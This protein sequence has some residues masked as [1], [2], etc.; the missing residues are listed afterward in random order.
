MNL[1]S[2]TRLLTLIG[3]MTLMLAMGLKSPPAS[4]LNSL[5]QPRLVLMTLVANYILVPAVTVALLMLFQPTPLVAAGFLI[6]AAC[7][8]APVA[9]PLVALAKGDTS[10]ST[11]QLILLAGTSAVLSPLLLWLLFKRLLPH[12]ELPID[13][14]ALLR[15]LFLLQLLPLGVGLGIHHC[16]PAFSAAVAKPLSSIANLLLLAV[17]TLLL[18]TQYDMLSEIRLRGWSGMMLLLGLSLGIGWLCGGPGVPGRMS[19]SLTTAVRNAA[20]ALVIVAGPLTGTP[21]ATAVVAFSLVSILGALLT[22]PLL[23][24]LACPQPHV[25]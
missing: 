17:I 16:R 13:Y 9:P 20:V 12:S 25:G 15:T 8:G 6:L 22:A 3:L 1:A 5:R 14:V 2:L 24:A 21:A 11:G 4:V 18:I 7:P 23:A 10:Q 19:L